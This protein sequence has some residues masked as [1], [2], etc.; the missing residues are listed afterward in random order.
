MVYKA[1]EFN[2][3]LSSFQ[4]SP[5]SEH[6]VKTQLG[7]LEILVDRLHFLLLS[8]T[9][10]KSDHFVSIGK[11]SKILMAKMMVLQQVKQDNNSTFEDVQ[12]HINQEWLQ[13]QADIG[14][15]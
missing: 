7:L 12:A 14:R 13:I 1:H 15:V 10:A 11:A 6:N 4:F 5:D 3:N 8:A 9:E 2:P